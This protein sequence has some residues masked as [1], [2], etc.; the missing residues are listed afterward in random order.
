MNRSLTIA[1]LLVCHAATQVDAQQAAGQPPELVASTEPKTPE[2]E[3]AGFHLPPGFK[4]ELVAC[5]PDIHK[6]MNLAFDNRGRLWV[7]SSLEYPFPGPVDEPGRDAVVILE[8]FGPEGRARKATTF[9]DGLNIPIGLLP[10]RQGALV[11]SIPN[12]YHMVDDDDDGRADRRD[13]WYGSIGYRDTHGMASALSWGFDG[14]IY[15][16]HGFANDSTVK[17]SDGQAIKMN[18]GNTYR[19]RPDGSHIEQYTWGQVNP[20]GLSFS[21]LGDLFSCDCHSRPIMMLLRGAYYSSFGKPHDGLGYGPEMMSHDHDSTGIAGIVY[22]A[23]EQFPDPWRETIFIGNVVTSRINHD[24]ITWHGSSPRAVAQPDFLISDDPWFRP[25]DIE[26]GPDGA[27]YVADF[28]N[29][30][31]GH[32]EVP[33]SHPGR[34]R[35]RG[36]IWRISYEG[37]EPHA[38]AKSPRDDWTRATARELSDD[39]G[40]G[41]LAVRLRAANELSDRNDEAARQAAREALGDPT[42][43]ARRVHALWTLLRQGSLTDAMIEQ[44]ARDDDR[45][46]RVHALRVLAERGDLVGDMRDLAVAGLGD[47]DPFARRAAAESL[48]RHAM[49][50]LVR[51]LLDARHGAAADDTHLLHTI[52]I[53]LRNQLRDAGAWPSIGDRAYSE[54]D[55]RALADVA[56]GVPSLE[57]ARFLLGYLKEYPESRENILRYEHHI[58]RHG[59]VSSDE[60]LLAFAR[61]VRQGG[62]G[63]QGAQLREAYQGWQER[64]TPLTPA[65][66]D[67]AVEVVSLLLEGSRPEELT[68]ALDL[69][70]LLKLAEFRERLDGLARQ[71]DRDEGVR[72]VAMKALQSLDAAGSVDVLADI[73]SDTAEPVSMREQAAGVLGQNGQPAARERLLDALA[74]APGRLQVAIAGQLAASG[75]GAQALLDRIEAGKASPR[76]LKERAVEPRLKASG[77]PDVERRLEEL[78]QGLPAG[79]ETIA[80]LLELRRVGFAAATTDAG[81]GAQVFEKNCATCHQIGGKGAKIGPQLDGVGIRGTDRLLEDILDPSRN[82]DQ[83]FRVTTLALNDGRVVTGL[84]LREEGEVL[85]LAD[86]QGKELRV[87]KGAVEQRTLAPLSLMPTSLDEQVPE[88]DLHDL[89]RFLLDQREKAPPG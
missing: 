15:A 8:D 7:T 42:N 2:E 69:A 38:D 5:E 28:Y 20:F 26:L 48:G 85:V 31:I 4:I 29:R 17:G 80:A 89:L 27:L 9:A 44:A 64:G 68:L 37:I 52:R 13:L 86:S 74:T 36:R 67:W 82:V 43:P 63:M 39:L 16:C 40:H 23:A 19:L 25:V 12:L 34:D 56:T 50:E 6:P 41:N 22:Y 46:V 21:P 54:P 1:M 70:G 30:I 75:D 51:P 55:L 71:R 58:A 47:S 3:R 14:W 73:L 59:D 49:K 33:L 62:L 84:L 83:A 24:R 53:A 72:V 87:E 79:N 32:Y 60:G 35:E 11:H 57:A 76:L 81:R 66:R 77:V 10:L 88:A 18:S 65:A 78:T 45:L 61:A